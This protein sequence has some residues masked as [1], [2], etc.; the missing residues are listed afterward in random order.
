[1]TSSCASEELQ[2]KADAALERTGY[3]D[4]LKF[5]I[6]TVAGFGGLKPLPVPSPS[7]YEYD[8]DAEPG[9]EDVYPR[10]PR[11]DYDLDPGWGERPRVPNLGE[12]PYNDYG[13]GARRGGRG[14][15]VR[16]DGRA[17]PRVVLAKLATCTQNNTSHA[18]AS[19]CQRR[20]RR[21]RRRGRGGGISGSGGGGGGGL[22]QP[23]GEL[24]TSKKM[25]TTAIVTPR[26]NRHTQ[27]SAHCSASGHRT[28]CGFQRRKR[29]NEVH[30]PVIRETPG[31]PS[32]VIC[33][34]L[35]A[36][37]S[38]AMTHHPVLDREGGA[39]RLMRPPERR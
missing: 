24:S 12:Y 20:R 25:M 16:L 31:V 36:C 17:L 18:R 2:R 4:M 37:V 28:G 22:G 5:G 8:Y 33:H 26:A 21:R 39:S 23:A 19:R 30:G 9:Y 27:I 10:E 32:S 38:D 7:P 11:D 13:A 1:M 35:V 15:R 3:W 34:S 29:A 14:G 6:D